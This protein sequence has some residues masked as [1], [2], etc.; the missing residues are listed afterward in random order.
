MTDQEKGV[1]ATGHC[2]CGGVRYT[3]RG[4]LRPVVQCHCEMCRRVCGGIW[5]ATAARRDDLTIED[6]DCLTWYRSSPPVRRGF[7]GRCGSSLFYDHQDRPII[8]IT[9]GTLDAPTGLKLAVHIFTA[10]AGDW[11]ELSDDG[12]DKKPGGPAGLK[13]PD[14]DTS[15]WT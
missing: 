14:S 13:F 10:D 8:G 1:R 5:N 11:Y 4:P 15:S 7:C 2:Y 9:A 12:V 3:V 6:D